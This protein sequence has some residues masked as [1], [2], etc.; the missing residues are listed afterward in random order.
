MK[1]LLSLL[2]LAGAV[3]LPA[4][5][6]QP[7]SRPL[8]GY[9]A[10]I[11]AES[12]EVRAE[13]HRR[14]AERR[15]QSAVVIVHRGASAF[16]PENTLEAY[17]AALD[18]GADGCEVDVRRTA[19]GVLVLFHDDMLD[20]LTDGF[21]TLPQL[22]YY[23]LL[24]LRPRFLYGTATSTTRPPTFAALL[25]LARQRSMLLFLDVKEEGL[26]AQI[27]ELLTKA[28]AWDQVTGVN[29]TTAPTLAKDPRITRLPS[30]GPGLFDG[31]KDVDPASV[32]A[33]LAG[34]GKSMMVDD[35]RLVAHE[36]KRPAYQ[37][38]PLA[39]DL[40]VEWAPRV[41]PAPR[42]PNMFVP[43]TYLARLRSEV[44]TPAALRHVLQDA[45]S[46]ERAN[47]DGSDAERGQRTERIVA[48]AWAAQ[49]LGMR[50]VRDRATVT[51]L[52]RQLAERSL[53]RDW[54]YHGM[55]GA[56][57]ARALARLG[58]KES[59]PALVRAFR[60]I[61]PALTKVQNPAFGLHP[62]AWTDFRTKMYV[63]PALGDLPCAESKAL[64]TEYVKL[65]EAAARELAPLLYEDATRALLRQDLTQ[66]DLE[67]LLRNP[68]LAVRGPALLECLDHPTRRRTLALKAA[69]PWALDLPRAKR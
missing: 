27:A 28:D 31:R 16:A 62:L 40:R 23:Q 50:G 14:V 43:T 7:A 9:T 3:L 61:D 20:H 24:S 37:P 11:S 66:A 4:Q 46:E 45:S 6:A 17:A 30:K 32:R 39:Q 49:Q 59:V 42:D 58:A 25:N 22:T 1:R 15:A 38:V 53:H 41:A 68:N 52:E 60:R 35:P 69:A 29:G 47:P 57:A 65:D 44:R 56:M 54:M 26:D 48:R 18:Y 21:G 51:L 55:D 12:S 67:A 34:P 36:L 63:L 33:Q 2:L 19:D 8:L 64:L 13:R 5:T 10:E